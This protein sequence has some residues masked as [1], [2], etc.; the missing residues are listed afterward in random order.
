MY[1]YRVTVC[2]QSL[3]FYKSNKNQ[4]RNLE[5]KKVSEVMSQNKCLRLTLVHLFYFF[6]V[7]L[8]LLIFSFDLICLVFLYFVSFCVFRSLQYFIMRFFEAYVYRVILFIDVYLLNK[9]FYCLLDVS[10]TQID[11]SNCVI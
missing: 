4:K 8:F 11:T 6:L 3:L 9:C 1:Y 10:K 2:V 7:F 5:S